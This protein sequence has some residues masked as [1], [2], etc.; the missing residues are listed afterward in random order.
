MCS[1]AAQRMLGTWDSS[2][3]P[4]T[5][6][7]TEGDEVEV[8]GLVQVDESTWHNVD[9]YISGLRSVL[10]RVRKC[11][12]RGTSAFW[13]NLQPS[14]QGRLAPNTR[15]HPASDQTTAPLLSH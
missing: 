3:L 1:S 5:Q 13:E 7:T 8:P 15:P 2:T 4:S 14:H 12:R 10:S 6:P 9:D 11:E